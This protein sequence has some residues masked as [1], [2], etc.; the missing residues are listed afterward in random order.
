M[1]NLRADKVLSLSIMT[2]GLSRA[3]WVKFVSSD[4]WPN[5]T[6]QTSVLIFT[7]LHSWSGCASGGI[8]SGADSAVSCPRA[9]FLLVH[10][11]IGSVVNSCL[12]DWIGDFVVSS[13]VVVKAEHGV[14]I[15]VKKSSILDLWWFE[16]TRS[17]RSSS[18]SGVHSFRTA[19]GRSGSARG[20]CCCRCRGLWC[21]RCQRNCRWHEQVGVCVLKLRVKKLVVKELN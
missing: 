18:E 5:D 15:V 16:K 7:A 1:I 19:R 3:L 10:I 20:R 13:V 9:A 2:D 11:C 17:L 6:N 14:A 8:L 4:G 12:E 21:G